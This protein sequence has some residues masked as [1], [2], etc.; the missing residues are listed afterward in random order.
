MI[1][2]KGIISSSF[3]A[4]TISKSIVIICN[5]VLVKHLEEVIFCII[6]TMVIT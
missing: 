2:R 1:K 6:C 3:E 4:N 5:D